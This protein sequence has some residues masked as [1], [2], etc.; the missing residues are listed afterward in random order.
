MVNTGFP[1][2]GGMNINSGGMVP[3]S[4]PINLPPRY[5]SQLDQQN[6]TSVNQSMP[7]GPMQ[8]TRPM[9]GPMQQQGGAGGGGLNQLQ[10]L[11]TSMN[12]GMGG[13]GGGQAVGGGPGGVAPPPPGTTADP[14]KRKLIQQ[15]LVLLLHAHKCQRRDREQQASGASGEAR[16]CT[17]PH[18]RTMKDVLNHM[19]TCQA[20]KTCTMAHCSSSRQIIAHWK[21]CSRQDCPVCLPLKQADNRRNPNDLPPGG[22]VIQRPPGPQQHGMAGGMQPNGQQVGGPAGQPSQAKFDAA[23]KALG[24]DANNPNAQSN[25]PP[26]HNMPIR[27]GLNPQQQQQQQQQQMGQQPGGGVQQGNSM[28]VMMGGGPPR[29][30]QPSALNRPPMSSSAGPQYDQ[31]ASTLME[32]TRNTLPDEIQNTVIAAPVQSTKEWHNMVTPDLRNH[33]VHKLVQV[34]NF[35]QLF[36]ILG[37]FRCIFRCEATSIDYFVRRI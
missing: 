32:P 11:P 2:S 31:I 19:T 30:G 9:G 35:S 1:N 7:N 16:Q 28:G 4:A 20:G 33:L 17:L 27:Q 14:E 10:M 25:Q 5:P 26:I 29:L 37:E 23:R 24:I 12:Q 21:H 22:P 3:G 36:A 8:P 13:G 15:Q 34:R 18:C 6:P